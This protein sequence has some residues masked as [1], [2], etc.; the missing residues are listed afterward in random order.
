[1]RQTSLIR[2]SLHD[3]L[4]AVVRERE[5]SGLR[6]LLLLRGGWS[7]QPL[8]GSLSSLSCQREHRAEDH[9]S[10]EKHY[11]EGS[12]Q[13][14]SHLTHMAFQRASSSALTHCSVTHCNVTHYA[15]HS[16]RSHSLVSH[17]SV[18]HC[19]VIHCTLTHYALTH[20]EI[21][22]QYGYSHCS[23]LCEGDFGIDLWL[24]RPSRQISPNCPIRQKGKNIRIHTQHKNKR[25]S[26]L[27]MLENLCK[28]RKFRSCT[29]NY[30]LHHVPRFMQKAS[31]DIIYNRNC[32]P[33]L[34]SVA[35]G[36]T[37]IMRSLFN[38]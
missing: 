19:A 20:Y 33:T 35:I 28:T 17:C 31:V 38:L 27:C 22:E 7:C 5:T 24:E 32:V 15:P 18:T 10:G 12:H 16:L 21:E 9:R 4:C 3:S 36:A 1:M 8:H 13:G 29:H 23:L 37:R 30:V 26:S 34:S 25:K 11:I 14:R 2:P 6:F